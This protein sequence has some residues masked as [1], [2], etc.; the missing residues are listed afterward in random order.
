MHVPKEPQHPSPPLPL[1]LK[2]HPSILGGKNRKED[3]GGRG[4]WGVGGVTVGQNII[5]IRVEKKKKN[6]NNQ[7]T[8]II[9]IIIIV[10][11]TM[12]LFFSLNVT[13]RI[14]PNCNSHTHLQE[15]CRKQLI[16]EKKKNSTHRDGERENNN[17]YY[18]Y[19]KLKLN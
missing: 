16:M 2:S 7:I 19:N 3:A 6:K 10:I 1:R 5:S 11:D 15:I 17:N 12:L 18:N 9:I 4:G 14:Q 8:T 13:T